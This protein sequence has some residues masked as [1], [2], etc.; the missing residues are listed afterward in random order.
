LALWVQ[1]GNVRFDSVTTTLNA[2]TTVVNTACLATGSI[3]DFLQY[4]IKNTSSGT[5]AQSG[6]SATA[7]NGTSTSGFAFMGINNSGTP[8]V[9]AYNIGAANDV[10]FMGSGQAMYLA[11]TNDTKS[12]FVSLG[13]AASPYFF[14][15]FEFGN[16]SGVGKIV[17]TTSTFTWT[18]T[19]TTGTTAG[20]LVTGAAHTALTASTES[21]DVNLNLARTVQFGTGALSTQRGMLIQ[22]PTYA[23]VGASTITTAATV[24]ISGAPVAGTNATITNAHALWVQSGTAKFDGLVSTLSSTTGSAGIRVPHGVAP[25]TPVDGDMWTTTSGLFLRVNGGTVGPLAAG[26]S[27]G[28]SIAANQVAF[29][30]GANA[31]QGSATLTYTATTGLAMALTAV[32]TGVQ[33]A[34]VI[35]GA[36]NTNLTL[37]TEVPDVNWNFARTVQWATGAIATQRAVRIQ[38]PTYAFVGASTITT[39]STL[40]VSNSPVAGTNATIT[41]RYAI[42][43]EAGAYGG[44]VGTAALPTYALGQ[45][46]TGMYSTGAG[47]IGFSSA[48][49]LRLTIDAT[50]FTGT[51][52]WRGQNGTAAAPA[53]SF[54]G[55][56]T[57][58]FYN[59]AT[60]DIG[61]AVNGV[62]MAGFRT[63]S[64][65]TSAN[66]N[67]APTLVASG[68]ACAFRVVTPADTAQTLS[69]ESSS[70]IFDFT[71]S[72]QWATGALA[73]QRAIN[74]IAPTYAFVA[75]STITNAATLAITAAPIAG[76]N[77]TITNSMALWVQAG[78]AR[79]DGAALVSAGS[80]AVPGLAIFGDSNTG[81]YSVGADQIG[82]S[83]GGV[84]RFDVSTTAV[85]STLPFVAPAA[86]TSAASARQ[87]HGTAPTSPVNGDEWTTTAGKFV[88]INGVT[89]NMT[90]LVFA[91]TDAATIAVDAAVGDVFTV[92]LAGNRTMGAPTNPLN[93][94]TALFRIQQDA[95][96][97]R[98]LTWNAAFAFAT[99]LPVPVLSTAANKVD[100][101]GFIYNGVTAKWECLSYLL[102]HN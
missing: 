67:I 65:Q 70:V 1:S 82:V 39:A 101:V 22:A 30:S 56:T 68:A 83:T 96:G 54:S 25:T 69:T 75:A 28:G 87:P 89:Y 7:D 64:T 17:A 47:F 4:D 32:A 6:Y 58:G 23:F 57:C 43:V 78:I 20:F 18:Q 50:A 52:P 53:L 99:S 86:T 2:G 16:N 51:L 11:N 55:N 15:V 46:N 48:G 45:A 98:T 24:A 34:Q 62:L 59:V 73:T 5:G 74:I 37:S 93:G 44:P 12:I 40:S 66:V 14:N 92:T 31:I 102:G 97:S 10:N 90:R 33:T 63:T 81:L 3:A 100:Y 60:N 85:T 26:G 61:V 29:G 88:R 76:T 38:A 41:N 71:A 35:T 42:N 77:A 91:L 21:I 84:L 94:R 79:F 9:A 80:A 8:L 72:R 36:A 19:A 49:T 27:I 13:K 95:T